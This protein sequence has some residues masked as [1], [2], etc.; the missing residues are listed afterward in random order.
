[1][2][3]I[4]IIPLKINGIFYLYEKFLILTEKTTFLKLKKLP[5]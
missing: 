5:T 1:M 2:F 3:I 4:I